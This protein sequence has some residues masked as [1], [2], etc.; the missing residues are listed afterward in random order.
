[1]NS[2]QEQLLYCLAAYRQGGQQAKTAPLAAGDWAQLRHL[3]SLHKMGPMVYETLRTVP[4]FCAGDPAQMAAW[5]R[6]TL[7]QAAGQAM[8]SGR[9]IQIG[10]ALQE[11]GLRYALLKGLICRELYA[12]PDLRTSGDEDVLIDPADRPRCHQVLQ[13]CG[14]VLAMDGDT[15]THWQDPATGLHIELH[16]QL[17]DRDDPA[18][19]RLNDAMMQQLDH[20]VA[21]PVSG[22]TV[23]TFAPTWHF[24]FL[25]CHALKHFLAGGVGVRTLCDIVSFAQQY[26]G[27]ID[28][29]A[30][31]E[32]LESILGRV[33][34][35]QIFAVGQRWLGFDPQAAGWCYSALPDP[36]DLLEDCLEA[37]IYGQSSM[38]RRHSAELVL[39]ARSTGKT[40]VGLR[41]ALFPARKSLLRR[42]PELERWPVLLPVCWCRRLVTYAG[43]VLHSGSRGNSPLESVA[44]GQKRA[45]MMQKYGILPQ[46]GGRR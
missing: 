15:V 23:Q 31:A 28:I 6:D 30:A 8:R 32:W 3:A 45:E 17:L 36:G 16:S 10:A 2:I 12:Q 19:A 44:L 41:S 24:V 42:Y 39:H 26:Q 37:G 22:G 35:D 40:R 38:S 27:Q 43:E 14:L 1:M 20:T 46:E 4:G 21:A 7:V 33:F 11:A 25:V 29:P 34:L 18:Q 5:K 9:M 13:N